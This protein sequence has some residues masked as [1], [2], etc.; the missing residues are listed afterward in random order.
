MDLRE[1]FSYFLFCVF[2]WPGESEQ[3]LNISFENTSSAMK[4]EC[5][6]HEYAF[7][8]MNEELNCS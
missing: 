6:M 7:S 3:S 4:T 1:C 5:C 8:F 2:T